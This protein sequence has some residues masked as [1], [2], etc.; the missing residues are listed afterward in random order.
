[1]RSIRIEFVQSVRHVKITKS[2]KFLPLVTPILIATI[3]PTTPPFN[4]EPIA[5]GS[6]RMTLKFA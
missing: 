2:A 6:A 5:I 1:M 4:S 3:T